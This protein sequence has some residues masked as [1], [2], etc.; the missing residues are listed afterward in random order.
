[1]T[2]WRKALLRLYTMKKTMNDDEKKFS[3][4]DTLK[5]EIEAER[6]MTEKYKKQMADSILEWKDDIRSELN[7]KPKKPSFLRRLLNT[8]SNE[9]NYQIQ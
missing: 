6:A 8:F 3:E 7:R 4:V 5:G 1:M 9:R 2:M